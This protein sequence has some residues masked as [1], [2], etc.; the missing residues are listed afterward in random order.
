MPEGHTI[1]RAALDQRPKLVGKR[2]AVT[3]PDGRYAEEARALDGRTLV[4]IEPVGKHLFYRFDGPGP[5]V[6]HVHLALFGSLRLHGA[7]ESAPPEPRGAVR[8]RFAADGAA[9]DLHGCRVADLIDDAAVAAIKDRLGPDPLC[10]KADAERVYDRMAK[11][12]APVAGLLM[13]Q[14]VV[15][16][17]GNIFRAEILFR[18]RVHP[19]VKG[20]ELGRE[21][22][23]AIWRD[24]VILLKIGV[25]YG[26]IITI[27]RDYAKKTHG[28][29]LSRLNGRQRFYVYKAEKCPFTGGPVETFELAG[30][31]VYFSP[32]WQGERP[33]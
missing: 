26:R 31:T 25:K 13:N 27:D 19:L 7:K 20:R 9:L 11:S 3:A 32:A 4:G 30:R 10:P 8:Y 29:P 21:R 16:G 12:P 23:D 5:N 18:Q 33:S 6:V 17:L 24:S 15:S 1:H 22:F 14:A 2:L 28:K